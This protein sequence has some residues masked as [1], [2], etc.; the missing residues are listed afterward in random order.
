MPY[1]IIAYDHPQMDQEREAVRQAHRDYLASYGRR[2]LGSGAILDDD[3]TTIIGGA[4]LLD[5]D[6]LDA[7]VRFEADDPYA[8][9]NIRARVEIV[10]WR[11]R[12]W[13]GN[14]NSAGHNPSKSTA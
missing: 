11:L 13:M 1:L 4:S 7:A 12:W 14:F 6:N 3:G 10:P 2:L 5:T 9:A 8:A